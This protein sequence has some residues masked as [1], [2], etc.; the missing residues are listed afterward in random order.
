MPICVISS[1][2]PSPQVRYCLK[3]LFGHPRH[4]H[5]PLRRLAG[6]DL[7]RRIW[8]GEGSVVA[9][10]LR[11][12][13]AHMERPAFLQLRQRVR[14]RTPKPSAAAVRRSLLW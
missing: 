2:L 6:A 12:A 14:E 8:A 11:C 13:A 10:L 5:P 1:S 3:R 7:Q 4:A 9:V